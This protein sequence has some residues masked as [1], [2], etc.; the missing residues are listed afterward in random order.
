[1]SFNTFDFTHALSAITT[2]VYNWRVQTSLAVNVRP[3]C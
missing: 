3:V 1:M 2:N